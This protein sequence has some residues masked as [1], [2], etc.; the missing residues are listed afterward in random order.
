LAFTKAFPDDSLVQIDV[1]SDHS[2]H[3]KPFFKCL[4]ASLA[5]NGSDS[6]YR[7]DGVLD[8]IAD[9]PA[10]AVIYDF[11]DS[12]AIECDCRS[13]KGHCLDHNQ[14]ERLR[15]IHWQQES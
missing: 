15:P 12:S 11:R 5:A 14:P 1:V 9:E 8:S 10:N 6:G 4:A 7:R 3:G 2:C 13:A